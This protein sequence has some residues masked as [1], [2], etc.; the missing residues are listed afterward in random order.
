MP[1][2]NSLLFFQKRHTLECSIHLKV[3]SALA[4]ALF[5]LF[6]HN[7]HSTIH[8]RPLL[9]GLLGA[10]TSS[11]KLRVATYCQLPRRSLGKNHHLYLDPLFGQLINWRQQSQIH[12]L[13]SVM[14]NK[15]CI[16]LLSFLFVACCIMLTTDAVFGPQ[17]NCRPCRKR[18]A[19]LV[20]NVL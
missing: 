16:L 12:S 1:K 2:R 11:T 6:H 9:Q 17:Y 10:V 7:H 20:M 4:R 3:D 15:K 13:L 8:L 5:Q 18:S 14:H 19:T